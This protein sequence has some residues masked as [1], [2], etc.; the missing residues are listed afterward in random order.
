MAVLYD[1]A[2][3]SIDTGTTIDRDAKQAA[4]VSVGQLD[5]QSMVGETGSWTANGSLSKKE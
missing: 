1:D 3:S 2:C 5:K 4:S